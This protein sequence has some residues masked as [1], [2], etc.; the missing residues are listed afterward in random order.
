MNAS[1]LVSVVGPDRPGL[2]NQLSRVITD[3]GGNWEG[4]RLIN[5]GGQ[6]AGIVQ[7]VAQEESLDQLRAQLDQLAGMGLTVSVIHTG[8]QAPELESNGEIL[9]LEVVGQ[10]RPGIVAAISETLANEGV[11]VIELAT[12]CRDAPMSG[13]RLFHTTATVS[14]P[15][16]VDSDDL[17]QKIEEIAG[18]LMVEIGR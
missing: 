1:L 13:E 2:V 11:N 7:V 14:V 5:L 6:F 18:D 9:I 16:S 12:D 17:R 15:A 10:D 3:A 4:S 8:G